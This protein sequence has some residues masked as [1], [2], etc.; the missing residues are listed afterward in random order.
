MHHFDGMG[1][2]DWTLCLNGASVTRGSGDPPI[3]PPLT[4]RAV[5][6]CG[7]KTKEKK[8]EKDNRVIKKP[9]ITT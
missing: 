8:R 7:S 9:V 3:P 1:M 2:A 4:P 6:L 5:K